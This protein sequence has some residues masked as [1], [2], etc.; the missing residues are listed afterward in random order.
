MTI[1]DHKICTHDHN[2]Y[3]C[4]HS[5]L[6]Y[7]CSHVMWKTCNGNKEYDKQMITNTM[8]HVYVLRSKSKH[9]YHRHIIN[10]HMST[11][12]PILQLILC[13]WSWLYCFELFINWL[14]SSWLWLSVVNH[15][16]FMFLRNSQPVDHHGSWD[17]VCHTVSQ[18]HAWLSCMH[19]NTRSGQGFILYNQ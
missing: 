13:H 12:I 5:N 16:L 4:T 2:V 10:V 1:D 18:Q 14:F 19:M 6:T 17:K 3:T 15:T 7:Q 9:R 8:L 11:E